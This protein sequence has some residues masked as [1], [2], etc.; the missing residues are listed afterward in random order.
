L[1]ILKCLPIP[2]MNRW[3]YSSCDRGRALLFR[4]WFEW[5]LSTIFN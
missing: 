3:I 4:N 2:S 5:E 1:T